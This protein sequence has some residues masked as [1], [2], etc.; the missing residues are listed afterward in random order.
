MV[1]A[2]EEMTNWKELEQIGGG[3]ATQTKEEKQICQDI[4][5]N[6]WEATSWQPSFQTLRE[7]LAVSSKMASIACR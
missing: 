6:S 5:R 4:G 2:N 1:E 7:R 3:E